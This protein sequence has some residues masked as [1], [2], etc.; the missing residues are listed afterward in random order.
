M[1][2]KVLIKAMIY[3]FFVITTGIVASVATFCFVFT[4]NATFGVGIFW[5]ILLLAVL[6]TLP[7]LIFYSPK[8]LN[9]KDWL[10]REVIHITV[11]ISILIYFGHTWEWIEIGNPKQIGFFIFLIL[12]VYS[13]VKLHAFQSD[14]KIAHQLNIGLKKY[15]HQ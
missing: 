10:V 2:M 1:D 7:H 4:R 8:E 5:K 14:R 3:S 13:V 6:T 12:A 15:N 9:K 11:L